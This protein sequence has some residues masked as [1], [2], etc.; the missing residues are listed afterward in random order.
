MKSNEKRV[1]RHGFC[2]KEN[3]MKCWSKAVVLVLALSLCCGLCACGVRPARSTAEE[4]EAVLSIGEMSAAYELYRY[5]FLNEKRAV[6]GGNSAFWDTADKDAYFATFDAAAKAEIFRLYS[7]FSLAEEAGLDPFGKKVTAMVKERLSELVGKD[8]VYEDRAAY[9][10][11][12]KQNYMTDSLSRLYLRYDICLELLSAAYLEAGKLDV[13]DNDA[14]TY[15]ESDTCVL[16]RWI[17]RPYSYEEYLVVRFDG[18][19]E[20]ARAAMR[21]ELEGILADA[22]AA[23]DEEFTS[24]AHQHF[25]DMYSDKEI[26]QGFLVGPYEYSDYYAALTE[27]CF[28]LEVGETSGIV[29]SGDGYYILRRY[30][31]PYYFSLEED[32][33]SAVVGSCRNHKLYTL[34]N[35]E[36]ERLAEAAVYSDFYDKLSF[37]SIGMDT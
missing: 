18:D 3:S 34:L 17:Y 22:V 33:V 9:L 23:D 12:I 8:G 26:A 37:D 27:A 19:R 32:A 30:E 36:A 2:G 24:L 20:A 10:A 13:S 29:E 1:L 6:D 14:L 7:L 15:Y 16:V 5:V 31:K 25:Q 28:A 4:R 21:E 11:A 35:A